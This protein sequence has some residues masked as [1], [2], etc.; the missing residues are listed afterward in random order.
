MRGGIQ[1]HM[2]KM[3]DSI[4][5][6]NNSLNALVVSTPFQVIKS[7]EVSGT[8]VKVDLDSIKKI[9]TILKIDKGIE[10][11]KKY[12]LVKEGIQ[13][14]K[15]NKKNIVLIL[16]ESWDAYR[17]GPKSKYPESTPFFN[18]L[19]KKGYN[20]TNFHS[21][22]VRSSNGL[23]CS[24]SGMYDVS[25]KPMMWR[26]E[27][28]HNF[29][30]ISSMLKK[31][32]YTN[33]FFTGGTLMFDNLK[34]MLIKAD[35]DYFA[36]HEELSDIYNHE[37]NSWGME[38]EY[39]YQHAIDKLKKLKGPW[40][41]YFL[42]TST[43]TPFLV[44]EKYHKYKNKNIPDKDLLNSLFYSD[45]MLEKFVNDLKTIGQ[46]ENT[47]FIFTADH[48]NHKNIPFYYDKNIPFVI[49]SPKND[50][51]EIS[52]ETL[53]KVIGSQVDI[54]PTIMEILGL[55]KQGTLGTSLFKKRDS[56][57]IWVSGDII[58]MHKRNFMYTFSGNDN[59]YCFNNET[60]IE[61]EGQHKSN[62]DI[63][64]GIYNLN[65]S[66]IHNN[67]VFK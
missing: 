46:Y 25:G 41:S 3:S 34:R 54:Q 56:Y 11:K 14:K 67:R 53:N 7:V 30:F 31:Y 1:N 63:L 64:K 6:S 39:I 52:Q 28:T 23:F 59:F 51:P 24:L 44:G 47:V 13:T 60:K 10:F 4:I 8:H 9:S 29:A 40:F 55:P 42:T 58:G 12:P 48:T 33:L 19:A 22:G 61:C 26:K 65:F 50:L 27:L 66:L 49:F 20:F 38:D 35:F 37:G 36:G 21:C 62:L 32:N 16:L 17:V 18:S 2:L 15:I 5:S 45:K 43:H 57:A